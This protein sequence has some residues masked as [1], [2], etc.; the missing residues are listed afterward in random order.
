MNLPSWRFLLPPRC[1]VCPALPPASGLQRACCA[2]CGS[3]VLMVCRASATSLHFEPMQSAQMVIRAG[4]QSAEHAQRPARLPSA[5]SWQLPQH[6]QLVV[7]VC[8]A[9]YHHLLS[10]N[11]S[12]QCAQ[13]RRH[14]R[15]PQWAMWRCRWTP[16]ARACSCWSPSRPGTARTSRCKT[17]PASLLRLEKQLFAAEALL[18]LP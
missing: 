1:S 17:G 6:I 13:E 3:Q 7:A 10:E 12:D 14:T 5:M 8:A 4:S 9:I 2:Q 11:A 18:L 15:R 16:T